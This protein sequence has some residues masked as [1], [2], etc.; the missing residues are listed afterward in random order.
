MTSKKLS[1]I[2]LISCLFMLWP[3]NKSYA[4]ESSGVT[5]TQKQAK[6]TVQAVLPE[7]QINDRISY[8]HLLV[9]P[10]ERQTLKVKIFNNAAEKQ[11]YKVE[12]IPAAT[13]KNG[14]ITYD[15]REKWPDVSMKVAITDIAKPK[16]TEVTVAANSEGV[17]EIELAVPQETFPGIVLG[18]IR[19]AQ[20]AVEEGSTESGMSL[21]N[22]YGYAIGLM[23]TEKADNPVYGETEL[24]L[25][26]VSPAIDYGSKV[27]EAAIRN[28]NPEAMQELTVYGEIIAKGN[29]NTVAEMNMEKVKIAPNSIFPLQ[30]DWGMQEVAAGDYTFKGKIAGKTNEWS[31]EE[32]FTITQEKA[33]EMNQ[34]TSFKVFVPDWWMWLFYLSGAVSIMVFVLL[35]SRCLRR[36]EAK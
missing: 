34:E 16:E 33:Q 1:T 7:N 17:A 5:E 36:K 10:N 4:A 22:T 12:V 24:E 20:K 2:L 27:L 23:L 13:N 6:F 21:N 35:I 15:E 18:G 3:S 28:P 14:L 29:G 19:I 8:Y 30:V 9:Q 11:S 32:D 25:V 26:K 31:F